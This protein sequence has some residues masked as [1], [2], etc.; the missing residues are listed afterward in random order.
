[1]AVVSEYALTVVLLVG[2]GLLL[3]SFLRL[4]RVDPRFRTEHVLS[5]AVNLPGLLIKPR[6]TY[7]PS[8]LE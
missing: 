2:A 6:P 3:H 4:R 8:M 1:M 7:G 5:M